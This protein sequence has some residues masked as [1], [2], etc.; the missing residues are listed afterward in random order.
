MGSSLGTLLFHVIRLLIRF[1]FLQTK[2]IG[3]SVYI[4]V[5]KGQC[6]NKIDV[7]HRSKEQDLEICAVQLETKTS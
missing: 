4:L 5:E 3:R 1:Q 7:C 6:F 2:T